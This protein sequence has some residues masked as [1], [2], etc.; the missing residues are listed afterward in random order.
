MFQTRNLINNAMNNENIQ[1]KSRATMGLQ[2]Y[3]PQNGKQIALNLI[4]WYH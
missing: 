3:C 1:T 4:M 2:M